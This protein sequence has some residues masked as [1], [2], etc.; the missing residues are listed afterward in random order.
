[1]G[2]ALFICLIA[3]LAEAQN[4]FLSP[5]APEADTAASETTTWTGV[6]R[7]AN[8]PFWYPI[9]IWQKR[10][11]D[12]LATALRSLHDGFSL[13]QTTAIFFISLVYS[14]IH[15]AG[16]G[17]GKLILG[18]YFL[19]SNRR[20]RAGDAA[21]AGGIVSLTHIGT[22]FLLSLILWLALNTLS[23]A[24]QRDMATVARRVGGVLVIVTG[25]ATAFVTLF[26][27]RIERFAKQTVVTRFTGLSLYGVAVLSGIVPCPLAWFVLVFTM[28]YG[29]YAYGILSIVGMAVGAAITVG[30]TG[31]IVLL[32]KQKAMNSLNVGVAQKIASVLRVAGGFVLIV[33]G[34]IMMVP[35]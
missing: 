15:T 11:N 10:I 16:P 25:T 2:F 7:E 3:G 1:M 4:P 23:M 9:V 5:D 27:N 12:R 19:T 32:A 34:S 20:L 13:V 28:S 31:L 18:T 17:H 26:Q 29:I 8:P 6:S 14:L 22:A 24:S 35:Q 30:G 21:V 33:L